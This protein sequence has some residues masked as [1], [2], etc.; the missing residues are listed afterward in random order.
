VFLARLLGLRMLVQH[1][2][3]LLEPHAVLVRAAS[4]VDLVHAATMVPFAASPRY[5]RA[6]RLSGAVAAGYAAGAMA[7]SPRS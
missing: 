4:A 1:G 5:G 3:V 6:A 2:A 7:V